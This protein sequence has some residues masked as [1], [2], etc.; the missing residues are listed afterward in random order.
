MIPTAAPIGVKDAMQSAESRSMSIDTTALAHLM[1]VLTNL[2]SDPIAAVIREYSTNAYDTQIAARVNLPVS[3]T[4]PTMNTPEFSVEDFGQGMSA[5]T[6]LDHYS[7][8]GRSDKRGTNDQVG[9]LGLGCKSALTYADQF[10][11]RSRKD[12]VETLALVSK[13]D[14]GVGQ[15]EIVDTSTTTQPNGTKITIPVRAHDVWRFT[16]KAKRIYGFWESGTVLVDG[17]EAASVLPDYIQAPGTDFYYR[18]GG[19]HVVLMGNVAYRVQSDYL[20][21]FRGYGVIIKA[22]LGDVSFAPSREELMYDNRTQRFIRDAVQAAKDAVKT[23]IDTVLAT[24]KTHAEALRLYHAN[25]NL[26]FMDDVKWVYKGEAI[27]TDFRADGMTFYPN[28]RGRNVFEKRVWARSDS[29]N[30]LWIKGYGNA[31]LSTIYRAGLRDLYGKTH[32]AI[33]L[34]DAAP[35]WADWVEWLDW[36]DIKAAVKAAGGSAAPSYSYSRNSRSGRI[37][38][39]QGNVTHYD[40]TADTV[41]DD[42]TM[43]ILTLDDLDYGHHRR[44]RAM[45]MIPVCV[46]KREVKGFLDTYDNAITLEDFQPLFDAECARATDDDYKAHAAQNT[47]IAGLKGKNILDP[48]ISAM[49]TWTHKIG[50]EFLDYQRLRK[51]EDAVRKVT[52]RYPLAGYS[53]HAANAEYV[54]ALYTYRKESK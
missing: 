2:Y 14:Q 12:G 8:Y 45:K 41:G 36:A 1:S 37:V 29:T 21:D 23:Q 28:R 50:R 4:L 51:A 27:P 46:Y 30:V 10:T 53:S 16:E 24:A 20:N 34:V 7:L 32:N 18:H 22:N 9:S 15:I 35:S 13:D 25:V 19:E 26:S 49:V 31:S 47:W 38:D 48:E 39:A 42:E 5:T 11:I 3:V 44:I 6:I 54:N 17:A 40:P 33:A 43:V 52:Q